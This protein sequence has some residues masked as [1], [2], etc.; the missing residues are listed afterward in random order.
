MSDKL[1]NK[2]IIV[3]GGNGLLGSAIVEQ[4]RQEIKLHLDPDFE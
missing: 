1:K 4:I 3:T 2:V